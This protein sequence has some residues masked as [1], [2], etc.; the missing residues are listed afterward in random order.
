MLLGG[1]EQGVPG[2]ATISNLFCFSMWVIIILYSLTTAV[3]QLPQL[4]HLVAKQ[5]KLGK[6]TLNFAYEV[7]LSY[8][9]GICNMTWK[10]TTWD[11]R[12]YFHFEGS[13]AAVFYCPRKSIVLYRVWTCQYHSTMVVHTRISPVGWRCWWLQFRD[14]V[15]PHR[16]VLL[17]HHDHHFFSFICLCIKEFIN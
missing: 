17:D 6:M 3:W 12:L 7:S 9:E 14:I 13:R 16:H 5:E 8:F 2:I 11:R 10:I 4:R 15:S 1:I